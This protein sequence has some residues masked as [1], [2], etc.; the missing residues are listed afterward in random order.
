MSVLPETETVVPESLRISALIH[1]LLRVISRDIYKPDAPN[2]TFTST[3]I[4]MI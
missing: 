1:I 3:I 2:S 4:K